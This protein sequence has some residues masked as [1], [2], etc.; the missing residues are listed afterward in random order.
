MGL[1]H[2][3]MEAGR[4]GQYGE[5][6]WPG[7]EPC[8]RGQEAPGEGAVSRGQRGEEVLA[9]APWRPRGSHPQTG[10]GQSRPL[11]GRWGN[12]G[13]RGSGF[14][15]GHRALSG[16]AR[17]EAS[18][19]LCT[20]PERDLPDGGLRAMGRCSGCCLRGPQDLSSRT[21]GRRP[22][23][24]SRKSLSKEPSSQISRPRPRKANTGSGKQLKVRNFSK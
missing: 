1:G 6:L 12:Q 21:A 20:L 2:G 14:A 11:L 23:R 18:H 24:R 5:E 3:S 15:R 16:K 4:A 9:S 8:P 10:W 17:G 7:V 19:I 13:L 22:D